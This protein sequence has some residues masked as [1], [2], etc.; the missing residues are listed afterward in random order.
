MFRLT[1]S[2]AA[3]AAMRPVRPLKIASGTFARSVTTTAAPSTGS[4]VCPCCFGAVHKNLLPQ[5]LDRTFATSSSS[6]SAR[7][8]S[9]VQLILKDHREVES[10]FARYHGATDQKTK[11]DTAHKLIKEISMHGAKEEMSVYPW[12]KKNLPSTAGMVDHGIREHQTLKED[13][14]ALDSM[15]V[16]DARFDATVQ[17][18]W[19]D[20]K[21]HMKEE[22]SEILPALEKKASAQDL[23][24]LGKTFQSVE[25]IAPSRP[26]PNAPSEG[27]AGVAANMGAKVIDSMRDAA[28]EA[29]K[30]M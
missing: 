28:R 5:S 10:L 26:H 7:S 16:S 9:V 22:E 12:M 23:S 8:P 15:S 24:D 1:A 11:Q 18:V 13:L 30:K 27:I 2:A 20:L 25:S 4:R 17:R 29:S 19:K 3:T 21:H 6:S 14:A